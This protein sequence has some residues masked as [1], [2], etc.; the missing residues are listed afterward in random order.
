M[1]GRMTPSLGMQP[2]HYMQDPQIYQ[3]QK[4]HQQ[5]IQGQMTL[6][7]EWKNNGMLYHMHSEAALGGVSS[8]V[9]PLPAVI[10][11]ELGGGMQGASEGGYGQGRSAGLEPRH[12]EMIQGRYETVS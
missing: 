2:E 11:D 8:G 7:P 9:L 6:F 12:N 4:L 3:Q 10:N 1:L 5:A